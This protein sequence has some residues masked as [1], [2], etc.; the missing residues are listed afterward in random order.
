[1][2]LTA[3]V[4]AEAMVRDGKTVLA[5]SFCDA[6]FKLA[7]IT[8]DRKSSQLRL[9]L[10]CSSPGVL[11]G[12]NYQFRLVVGRNAALRLETQSYQRIFEMKQGASQHFSV[13]LKAGASFTYLPHP[14]VPHK[15]SA[16]TAKNKIYL[17]EDCSLVWGEV[18]SCGRK[19]NDEIFQFN[20]YHSLTEIFLKGKLVVKENLYLN[21]LE[22]KLANLGHMEGYT[23]QATLLC[24]HPDLDVAVLSEVLLHESTRYQSVSFGVSALPVNGV[25]V[26]MLGYKAEVL[27]AA[28][29]QLAE[30]VQIASKHSV[31]K[32]EDHV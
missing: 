10:M 17:D 25:V 15:A 16:F 8:E 31:A 3:T 27:F 13:T 26:R 18:V 12:D 7:D 20:S 11:D 14:V 2:A 29:K 21:P 9:M 19:L 23:H 5:S 6:P 4:H 30:T 1:M 28:V 22:M 32:T 24:I